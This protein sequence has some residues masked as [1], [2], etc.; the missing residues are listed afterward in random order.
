MSVIQA[1]I[2]PLSPDLVPQIFDATVTLLLV[3]IVGLTLRVPPTEGLE[4]GILRAQIVEVF[5][6]D[7]QLRPGAE[8]TVPFSR[9]ANPDERFTRRF[10]QWNALS[11]DVGNHLLL[12]ANCAADRACEA[13]AAENAA[14]PA[15]ASVGEF[16]QAVRLQSFEGEPDRREQLFADAILNGKTLLRRYAL[17]AIALHGLVSRVAGVQI[18]DNAIRSPQTT[19]DEKVEFGFRVLDPALFQEERHADRANRLIVSVLAYGL[20]KESDSEY[21]VR[22][23]QYLSSILLRPFSDDAAEAKQIKESLVRPVPRDIFEGVR[24]II[25]DEAVKGQQDERAMA[26]DL[27]PVWLLGK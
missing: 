27:L 23:M 19:P 20:A 16:R 5:R 3:K 21:R 24:R 10:D 12:A 1:I 8:V 22:W 6:G 2:G 26:S 4:Q 25:S 17:D 14:S 7:A 11:L 9:I 13:L 18:L 15:A